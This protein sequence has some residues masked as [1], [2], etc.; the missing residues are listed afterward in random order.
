MTR[1]SRGWVTFCSTISPPDPRRTAVRQDARSSNVRG[2]LRVV[3]GAHGV[4]HAHGLFQLGPSRG[5][6][7]VQ[8]AAPLVVEEPYVVGDR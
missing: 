7:L 8:R 6:A 3:S 1:S 5:V 2:P 4:E